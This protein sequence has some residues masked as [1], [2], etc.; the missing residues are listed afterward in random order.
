MKVSIDRIENGI[1][2]LLIR[3]DPPGRIHLSASL[4]PSG[5][6]EGDLLTLTL[7]RDSAATAA[8][9]DRVAGLMKKIRK[10]R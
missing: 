1:A 5:C 2:V 8:A 3:D 10:H 7:E 4:L 6:T 9:E